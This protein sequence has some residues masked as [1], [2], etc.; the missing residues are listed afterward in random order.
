VGGGNQPEEAQRLLLDA[1]E[2]ALATHG[3]RAAT[4]DVIAREAGYTRTMLYRHFANRGE[5]FEA[6]LQRATRRVVRR[7][8]DRVGSD[9]AEVIVEA[10]VTIATQLVGEP[11]YT[12]FAEQAG[13]G[14][15]A[16]LL[17]N[18]GPYI[19]FV[20]SLLTP[21]AGDALRDDLQTRDVAQFLL[22]IAMNFVLGM[23]PGSDDPAVVRHYVR[24]FVLPAV[25]AD[26][27]QPFS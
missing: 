9:P 8:A 12:I 6:L 5:L 18:A 27:P 24:S 23:V 22:T 20:D 26:R 14:S 11:L 15:V 7:V 16:V 3:Y 13:A 10:Y 25:L 4:M 1:A 17:T 21:L 19:D 2:R